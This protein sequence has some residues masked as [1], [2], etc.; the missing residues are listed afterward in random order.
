LQHLPGFL[1]PHGS[2]SVNKPQF[3]HQSCCHLHLGL[4][5]SQTVYHRTMSFSP[6]PVTKTTPK[7]TY[8]ML[9]RQAVQG[10]YDYSTN[11]GM[12]YCVEA[13]KPLD[14]K[15]CDGSLKGLSHFLGRLSC[16][17]LGS[18]WGSTIKLQGHDI[19]SKY[20]LFNVQD[21]QI[22]ALVRFQFDSAGS[23]IT[24]RDVQHSWQMMTFFMNSC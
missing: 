22:K 20:G 16:R 7:V 4:P 3:L 23:R 18:G 12:K 14:D 19:F 9:P 11:T 1:L 21:A 24:I 17:A 5:S 13:T 8:A 10:L 2:N 15:P 6:A